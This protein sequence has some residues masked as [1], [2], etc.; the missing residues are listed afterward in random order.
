MKRFRSAV[1]LML[2]LVLLASGCQYVPRSVTSLF[3]PQRDEVAAWLSGIA[4][5]PPEQQG[6]AAARMREDGKASP[7]L[8]E[9]ALSVMA[10][11]PGSRAAVARSDL[12]QLAARADAAR[13][14]ALERAYWTDLDGMDAASMRAAASAVSSAEE[15]RFPWNL[16]LLKAARRGLV[17]DSAA[18]LSRVAV[19]GLYANP[20]ALGISAAPLPADNAIHAALVVPLS[21]NGSSLGRQVA[22]GAAAAVDTLRSRG[23]TLDVRV[24]DAAAGD[25][26]AQVSALSPAC[27]LI[28]GPL[29]P[30]QVKALKNAATGRAVF[31]FTASLPAGFTEGTDLWRLFTSSEDQA[32]VLL[33]AAQALGIG[34]AGIFSPEDAYSKHMNAVFQSEAQKRGFQLSYGTYTAGNMSGWPREASAFL[35]T[36]IGKGRGSIPEATAGFQAIFLPDSWKNMDMLVSSLH[37]GGA[38]NMLMMGT[39]LWEQSLGAGSRNNAAAFSLTVFPAAW[40]E[41]SA[42]PGAAAFRSAMS[43]SGHRTDDWAALG[44][45]FVQMAAALKLQPGWTPQTLNARLSGLRVDWAAAPFSWD[46]SGKVRRALFL[47]R[48]AAVGSEAVDPTALRARYANGSAAAAPEP[49]ASEPSGP[50]PSAT[51][52]SLQEL[53]DSIT[54]N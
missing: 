18:V 33:D 30:G 3:Q 38:H 52:R 54:P 49:S 12:S 37:Y 5:L 35:K 32:A 47:M 25:W 53:V 1:L 31:T 24:I 14:A 44:F 26:A 27:S 51:A 36:R 48:P 13:R 8:R 23:L 4:S 19:P 10:S 34:S 7:A 16:L 45:D 40:N 28:G 17:A 9:R 39:T 42:A 46:G 15:T 21:G 50:D 6:L 29:L 41:R 22:A 11:R 43:A 2:C 20:A